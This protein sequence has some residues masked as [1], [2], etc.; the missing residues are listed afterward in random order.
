M[1]S[2]QSRAKARG[3]GY[4][5]KLATMVREAFGIGSDDCKSTPA[6]V[7]GPDLTLSSAAQ[8][9]FPYSLELKYCKTFSIP[10]W[11]RQVK[12][13]AYPNTTPVVVF[14]SFDQKE[15]YAIV[16]LSHFISL[17][18]P[19]LLRPCSEPAAN[20]ATLDPGKRDVCE[21]GEHREGCLPRR[22]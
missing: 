16:P 22:A 19:E 18:A 20:D 5:R 15:D 1:A 12:E 10:A 7:N 8:K 2:K 14:H 9:L 11:L 4:Q 21:G 3:M 6:G 17:A 13:G